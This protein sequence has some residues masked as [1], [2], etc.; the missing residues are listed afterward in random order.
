[1]KRNLLSLML[2]AFA[3]FLCGGIQAQTLID[4]HF[5]AFTEG[6]EES[7]AATDISGYSGKLFKQIGWSG[8]YVDEAGGSCSSRTAEI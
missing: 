7:P 4:E 3:L 6:S 2:L 8:K 1:M 5:D